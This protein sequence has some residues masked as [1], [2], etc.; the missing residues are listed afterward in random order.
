MDLVGCELKQRVSGMANRWLPALT[1]VK[2]AFDKRFDVHSSGQIV[3]LE[4]GTISFYYLSTL[5]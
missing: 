2:S 1:I 3:K 4:S 5:C